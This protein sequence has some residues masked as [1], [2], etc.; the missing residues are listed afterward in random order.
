M[1][2]TLDNPLVVECLQRD[3]I[4][5]GHKNRRQFA[6]RERHPLWQGLLAE[7]LLIRTRAA[8]AEACYRTLRTRYPTLEALSSARDD[9]LMAILSAAG[10]RWRSTAVLGLVREIC[11]LRGRL[12]RDPAELQRLPGVG[13]YVAS[14]TLTFHA[15]IRVPMVDG[16]VVRVVARLLGK[17]YGPETRRER[18]LREAVEVLTPQARSRSFYFA[19][20]DLAASICRPT[21][22]RCSECPVSERCASAFP[23][24]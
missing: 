17:G 6:W 21:K 5:W 2:L 10:L 23:D 4:R 16:N 19:I 15:G 1:L 20:L 24:A 7:T 9:D 14:A 18:W 12:P 8:Q 13:P 3:L 11:R 22:P